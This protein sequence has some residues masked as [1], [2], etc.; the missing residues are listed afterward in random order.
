MD[1]SPGRDATLGLASNNNAGPGQYDDRSYELGHNMKSFTIGE[2]RET[3]TIETA[4]PGRYSPE[5][6]DALTKSK[7]THSIRIDSSTGHQALENKTT[8]SGVAPGTYDDRSY[9]WGHQSKGFTIGEKRETMI[10]ETAGPGAYS[11]ERADNLV[12]S[13][14]TNVNMGS[15]PQ[16]PARLH[17]E[18]PEGAA[19]GQYDDRYYEWGSDSKG[20]TIGERRE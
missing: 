3:K 10:D 14:V 8:G 1:S 2:R 18:H 7:I 16:R 15:S 11:P 5:R 20:F 4:G 12:K 9:E 19:P 13:K 17:G 6:A